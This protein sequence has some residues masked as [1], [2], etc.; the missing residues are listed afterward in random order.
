MRKIDIFNHIF[1]ERYVAGM[2]QVAPDYK[3][4]GKRVRGVPMLVVPLLQYCYRRA[5]DLHVEF[6][7][8]S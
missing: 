7:V 8:L 5:R 6:D 4:A 3:D 2:R 1:P